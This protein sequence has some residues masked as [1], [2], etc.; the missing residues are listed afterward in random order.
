MT[1]TQTLTLPNVPPDTSSQITVSMWKAG[2]EQ[3]A[4]LGELACYEPA[5][6]MGGLELARNIMLPLQFLGP[7]EDLENGVHEMLNDPTPVLRI[8]TEET[9]P[10][11]SALAPALCPRGPPLP[12]G[13]VLRSPS[14][15]A[16]QEVVQI[17]TAPLDD[18]IFEIP[19]GYRTVE[20]DWFKSQFMSGEIP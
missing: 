17:S 14:L 11:L 8:H 6:G 15:S 19:T 1:F 10:L 16:T 13:F 2:A 4:A 12:A 5:Y 20:L 3:S 18:S 9:K 7:F